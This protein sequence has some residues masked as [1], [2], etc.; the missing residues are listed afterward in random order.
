MPGHGDPVLFLVPHE[1]VGG[2]VGVAVGVHSPHESVVLEA[3][4]GVGDGVGKA[5]GNV[6][7]EKEFE[8]NRS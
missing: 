1:G 6:T 4:L 3:E 2:R 7:E 8:L 5:D